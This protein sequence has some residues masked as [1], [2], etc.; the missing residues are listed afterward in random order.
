M[1]AVIFVLLLISFG[2]LFE[3][4]ITHRVW[5]RV[6]MKTQRGLEDAARKRLLERRSQLAELKRRESIWFCLEQELAFSGLSV[7]YPFLTPELFVLGN[8]ILLSVCFLAGLSFGGWLVA[9]MSAICLC[10]MEV[11]FLK[12]SKTIQNKKVEG[13][14]LKLLD[15]MGNYS[16]T[17]GELTGVLLQVSHY[18]EEPLKRVLEDCYYEA[19][20]TG[21]ISM[22]LLSMAEKV[23]HPQ[24]QELLRNLEIS[25]RYSADLKVLVNHSRRSV[26]EY[27]RAGR[28]QKTILQEAFI[29][30][31]LLIVMS[32]FAILCVSNLI[33]MS[34]M[35]ILFGSLICK[36]A[37]GVIAIVFLLF[38]GKMMSIHA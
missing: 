10:I 4:M 26:R 17:G 14:L 20:L 1:R 25:L 2:I 11:L 12:V 16:V 33:G 3:E 34:V 13:Q 27:L 36:I 19:Q 31:L 22:A 35:D 30:M 37:V 6:L 5:A 7:K 38:G 9:G 24:F 28:E 15:F 18:M 29:S 23:E 32:A 8:V 21:D